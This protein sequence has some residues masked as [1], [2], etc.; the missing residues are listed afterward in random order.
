MSSAKK[1][2]PQKR[3]QV[4]GHWAVVLIDS[5]PIRAE[6]KAEYQKALRDLEGSRKQIETFEA[7]D[8]PKFQHWLNQ[9]FGALL[10]SLRE[11]HLQLETKRELLIAVEEE[12]FSSGSSFGRAYQRVLWEREHPEAETAEEERTERGQTSTAED[13]PDDER[14]LEDLIGE[15]EEEI[16]RAFGEGE[17]SGRQATKR[18]PERPKGDL[19]E[20][21]RALARRLHPDAQGELTQ[22]QTEWWHQVQAAYENGDAEQLRTI[23]TLCEIDEHGITAKTSVSMLQRSTRQLRLSLRSLKKQLSELRGHPAWGFS[24]LK[25]TVRLRNRLRRAMEEELAEMQIMLSVVTAQLETWERQA[26]RGGRRGAKRR[27]SR[28]QPEFF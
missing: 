3:A 8:K 15:M 24:R 5:A 9:T 26:E 12:A 23:L 2:S 25:D 27:Q 4:R 10:T 13:G 7:A 28:N 21:Y 17:A 1:R 6:A 22:Q 11:T 16:N 20:L 14:T 19:K 18:S